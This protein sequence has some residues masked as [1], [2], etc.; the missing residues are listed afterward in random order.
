MLVAAE[1]KAEFTVPGLSLFSRLRRLQASSPLVSRG[2]EVLGAPCRQHKVLG[3]R[4]GKGNCS[5]TFRTEC[6]RGPGV[7]S[8]FSPHGAGTALYDGR[9]LDGL[10]KDFISCSLRSRA[11]RPRAAG[12]AGPCGEPDSGLDP[13][14]PGS[15]RGPRGALRA[16]WRSGSPVAGADARRFPAGV[17]AGTLAPSRRAQELRP[18][19]WS[20]AL[21]WAARSV[22]LARPPETPSRR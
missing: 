22:A 1:N 17:S 4:L 14:S 19:R 12:E 5:P 2:R 8:R 20:P 13:G 15:R 6:C 3:D 10:F 9:R 11:A 7:L 21:S 16:P 18:P